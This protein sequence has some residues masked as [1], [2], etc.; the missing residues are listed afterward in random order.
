MS[1]IVFTFPYQI[2]H[3]PTSLNTKQYSKKCTYA[4]KGE[5]VFNRGNITTR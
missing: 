2:V 1:N 5:G 4:N 3:C